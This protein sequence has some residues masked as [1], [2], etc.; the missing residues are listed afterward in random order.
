[1]K[2]NNI[3]LL[4]KVD[5]L[6]QFVQGEAKSKVACSL[7]ATDV[8][9]LL[10]APEQTPTSVGNCFT[11]ISIPK[12]ISKL[13]AEELATYLATPPQM[14]TSDPLTINRIKEALHV[15]KIHVFR[16]DHAGRNVLVKLQ[17]QMR[18]MKV[19]IEGGIR[20]WASQMDKP[21]E[22]GEL[23]YMIPIPFTEM[24]T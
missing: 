4:E 12:Q 23:N 9:M 20:K 6:L 15:L 1:M 2:A 18:N 16:R 5:C 21:W 24:E 17:H 13:T 11:N 10:T 8:Q 22:A 19:M 7:E 3:T 14:H